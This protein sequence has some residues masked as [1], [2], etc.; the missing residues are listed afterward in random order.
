MLE[1]D[2][3]DAGDLFIT[4]STNGLFM[5]TFQCYRAGMNFMRGL[6]GCRCL[7]WG[8][9][10]PYLEGALGVGQGSLQP[11]L[12]VRQGIGLPDH[13]I[14]LDAELGFPVLY[15]ID[16]L[17]QVLGALPLGPLGLLVHVLDGAGQ[18]GPQALR[19]V[20]CGLRLLVVGHVGPVP[21]IQRVPAEDAIGSLGNKRN[22][23]GG[24]KPREAFGEGRQGW[25]EGSCFVVGVGHPWHAEALRMIG[26]AV[27][28]AG[29][30]GAGGRQD[31]G[32]W[33]PWLV[34]LGF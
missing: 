27:L 32:R 20:P 1:G 5:K 7:G 8:L 10:G 23:L 34:K 12:H 18:V 3:A 13:G 28:V 14:Q 22:Y 6:S 33:W 26:N 15:V 30:H 25:V 21:V 24:G 4:D 16:A 19:V 31:L 17:S 2:A 29:R 11:F 9:Q